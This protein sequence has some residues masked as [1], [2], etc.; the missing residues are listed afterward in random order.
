MKAST[1][2]NE[3]PNLSPADE[4]FAHELGFEVLGKLTRHLGLEGAEIDADH[5]I[6]IM[7]VEITQM[8][9]E[10]LEDRWTVHYD[11]LPHGNCGDPEHCDCDCDG[12]ISAR[13][14]KVIH[15]DNRERFLR[16]YKRSQK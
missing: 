7:R 5:L 12:C 6:H 15:A 16:E 8:R 14:G 10:C 9:G 1:N 4:E 3:A 13:G 11:T 2:E